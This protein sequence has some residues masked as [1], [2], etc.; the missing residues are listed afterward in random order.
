MVR[1]IFTIISL[2]LISISYSQTPDSEVIYHSTKITINNG[3]LT[4]TI[5]YEIKINNRAGEN[6][7][8]ISIPFSKMIKVSK[9][10]AYI[11]DKTGNIIKKLKKSDVVTRSEFADF[12]FYEDNF[13]YEFT[14]KH[15]SYPYTIFYSYL[16]QE[17]EFLYVD[18]WS[19]VLNTKTPTLNAI[20]EV[21]VPKDYKILFTTRFIDQFTID[22]TEKYIK[23]NWQTSYKEFTEPEILMPPLINLLPA[24][25]IVPQEFKYDLSGSFNSWITFG[26]WHY[27]LLQGLSELPLNEKYKI[28]SL[29]NGITD[30]REKIKILYKYLQDETR[31][32]NITI[33]TGGLKPYPASYVAENK[34][35]DCKALSNYFKAVLDF[36]NIPSI[37]T[38]VYAG[39]HNKEINKSF[40][41]QQFNH[42][43]L[44]VPVESDTLWLDCTSDGPFN[45]LGTF[46][47]NRDVFMVLNNE[48]HFTRT[49]ALLP[50]DVLNSRH[51]EFSP[52]YNNI[53]I[54]NMNATYRGEDYESLFYISRNFGESRKDQ[55]IRRNYIENE[56]EV[57]DFDL[58]DENKDSAKIQLNFTAKTTKIYK[59]YG[60]EILIKLLPFSTPQFEKP[61]NRKLSVQID[62]P[63]YNI[64]T[65][66]YSIQNGYHVSNKLIDQEIK[67]DFG[68]YK[69][70][71]NQ[72]DKSVTVIKSFLL[73]SGNYSIDQFKD[74]YSFTEKINDLENN[75][76]I[77][78]TNK[79]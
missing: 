50:K 75:T 13:V 3:Q 72:K 46:T 74:L 39:E 37:Y 27:Q 8:K 7:T 40:P 64:D 67:S 25:I 20:L 14:L 5:S 60:N 24:V 42:I 22:T 62:Y 16:E 61:I 51:V 9:I 10:E 56:F 73:K 31:Y 41:S 1:Y 66:V 69:I 77:I 32:I 70:T 57:A 47:Q 48:S 15:N 78:T 12:S 28:N 19:P 11:K 4:K 59:K 36:A 23:Y 71:F 49:P 53:T 43:I 68:H 6:L 26:N 35:G 58:I 44:C 76:Y 30:Q 63:I 65:L 55:I 29:I 34:F 54:A 17:D 38:K 33:E 18:Y 79:D 52:D 45:Y 2:F 21:E